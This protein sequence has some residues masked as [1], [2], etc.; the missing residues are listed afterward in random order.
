MKPALPQHQTLTALKTAAKWCQACEL[1]QNATHTVFG[2]GD[3]DASLV[4]VADQ[5]EEIDDKNGLP[6]VG[7]TGQGVH[8]LIE[9]AG[10]PYGEVYVT[11]AV[12][13][14]SETPPNAHHIKAC[15][16]WLDAEL[17]LLKPKILLCVGPIAARA[18][19]GTPVRVTVLSGRFVQS[20]YC[21]LTLIATEDTL[22]DDI[23]IVAEALKAKESG[24]LNTIVL[25]ERTR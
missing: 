16:P 3:E 8:R 9:T 12:K 18:V 13:H 4:V 19:M 14:F 11:Y 20:P 1:Y 21:P 23:R 5:P 22:I 17:K 7:P 6:F 2:E 10:I 25:R 24:D 15:R